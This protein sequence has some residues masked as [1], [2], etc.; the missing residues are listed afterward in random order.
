MF[1][2]PSA[3]NRFAGITGFAVLLFGFAEFGS[4]LHLVTAVFGICIS[5]NTFSFSFSSS[6][7]LLIFTVSSFLLVSEV[8]LFF[9]RFCCIPLNTFSFSFSSSLYLLIFTVRVIF[10]RFVCPALVIFFGSLLSYFIGDWY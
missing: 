3:W 9:G 5:L 4:W 8:R 10:G 2:F 7:F 1:S 6:L